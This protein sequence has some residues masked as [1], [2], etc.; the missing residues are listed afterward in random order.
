M[1]N[2]WI[3]VPMPM[4]TTLPPGFVAYTNICQFSSHVICSSFSCGTYVYC[5][6]YARFG[7][8]TLKRGINF[9]YHLWLGPLPGRG[10]SHTGW[11][12]RPLDCFCHVLC[13]VEP[14]LNRLNLPA[15][16]GDGDVVIGKPVLDCPFGPILIDI[17]NDDEGV[18]KIPALGGT[19]QTHNSR[20]EDQNS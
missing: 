8:G 19:H 20:T 18:V 9:A 6:L 3:G 2:V 1:G 17:G 12:P 16:H 13:K 7:A 11:P 5:R 14:R 15:P 10:R 4:S